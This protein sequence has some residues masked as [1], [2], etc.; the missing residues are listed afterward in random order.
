MPLVNRRADRQPR[1]TPP[2][3]V[4]RSR[5]GLQVLLGVVGVVAVVAGGSAVISGA[6]QVI[7]GEGFSVNVDSEFRFFAAWYVIAGVLLLRAIPDIEQHGRIVC[8][9]AAGFVL[10]ACGR[11]ISIVSVGTPDRWYVLLTVVELVLPL[12]II[13][14]QLHLSRRSSGRSVG[15]GA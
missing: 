13:P 8:T 1:H 6:A 9:V 11:L 15:S 7:G 3:A 12:V 4:V 14:W 5:L 10:A 2:V